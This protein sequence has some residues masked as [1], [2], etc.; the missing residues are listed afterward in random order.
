MEANYF[1]WK[2][3]PPHSFMAAVI[4]NVILYPLK[5]DLKYT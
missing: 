1:G 5:K 3:A 2:Q 4:T